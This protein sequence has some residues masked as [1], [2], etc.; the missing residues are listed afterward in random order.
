MLLAR[1]RLD[2]AQKDYEPYQNKSE[3]NVIRA[4][5]LS[6]LAQAQKNYDATVQTYNNLLGSASAGDLSQAKADLAVTQANLAKAQRDYEI[7]QK[8]PDPDQVAMAQQ[9]LATAQAQ[10]AAAKSDLNDVE[11]RAPLMGR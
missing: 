4:A 5:L 2:R 7:L 6:K 8:G 1:D 9:R 3:N 10:V 11:L